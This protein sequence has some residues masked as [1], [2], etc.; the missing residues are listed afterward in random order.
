MSNFD[1][2]AILRGAQLTVVGGKHLQQTVAC[3]D[4]LTDR[5]KPT[6]HYRIQNSLPP[7]TIDRLLWPLQLVSLSVSLS[8]FLYV[9]YVP[10]FHNHAKDDHLTTP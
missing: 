8:P 3:L 1:P 10:F 7:S 6:E 5:I 4:S 9:L 2:N